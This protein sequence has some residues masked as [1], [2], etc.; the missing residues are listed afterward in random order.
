MLVISG[1]GGFANLLARTLPSVS[2]STS[3]L[4]AFGPH[5]ECVIPGGEGAV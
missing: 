4:P 2:L 1:S 5:S 3:L